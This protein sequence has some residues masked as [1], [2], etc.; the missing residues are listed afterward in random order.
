MV[1][2]FL[3]AAAAAAAAQHLGSL[4]GWPVRASSSDGS[5][6]CLRR[7]T[8]VGHSDGWCGV[9][10]GPTLIHPLAAELLLLRI[11][12]AEKPTAVCA[13]W[14]TQTKHLAK[15]SAKNIM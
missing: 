1:I 15:S 7:S 12:L 8:G 3:P 6:A 11:Q 4:A 10:R 14:R 5:L 2:R 9:V 13:F